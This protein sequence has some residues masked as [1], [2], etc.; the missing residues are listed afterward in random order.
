M[1]QQLCKMMISV[2]FLAAIGIGF[3]AGKQFSD[4]QHMKYEEQ[5]CHTMIVFAIDKVEN[6]KNGYDADDMEALLSNVYAAKEY[7][8]NSELSCALDDLWNALVFDG[9][10]IVGKE[11]ALIE[12]LQNFDAKRIKYIADSMRVLVLRSNE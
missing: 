7:T 12:A 2:A 3:F 10:N 6:L 4:K 1:N 8:N 11:D 5:S 9:E